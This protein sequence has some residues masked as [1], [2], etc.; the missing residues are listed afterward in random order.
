M[1]I[2]SQTFTETITYNI[3]DKGEKV[4]PVSDKYGPNDKREFYTVK[5]CNPPLFACDSC[6]LFFEEIH[7]GYPSNYFKPFEKTP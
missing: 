5:E 2:V 4:V 1:K 3:F 7:Y 6:I